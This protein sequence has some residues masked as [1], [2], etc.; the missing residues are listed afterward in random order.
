[1]NPKAPLWAFAGW[2]LEY[3]FNV[4]LEIVTLPVDSINEQ[5]MGKIKYIYI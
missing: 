3:L 4:A 2:V 1:M 5:K